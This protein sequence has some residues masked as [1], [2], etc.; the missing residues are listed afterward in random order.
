MRVLDRAI[1]VDNTPMTLR[2][3]RSESDT[4]AARWR[5]LVPCRAGLPLAAILSAASGYLIARRSLAPVGAMAARA[6]QITAERL[7]ARLPV[8]N[9]QD[10]LGQ[11][12]A[13]FNETLGRLENSF[14]ELRRFAADASHELRTPLTA[15]RAVGE[16]S[17]RERNGGNATGA[18]R[19][20]VASMLEEA[21]HLGELVDALLLLARADSGTSAQPRLETVALRPL[22]AEARESLLVLAEEKTQRIALEIGPSVVNL[23]AQADR[24][25]LR[26]ALLNLIHNAI[27][28]S[29][30]ET[31]IRLRLRRGEKGNDRSGGDRGGRRRPRYRPGA[32]GE[33]V[34]AVLPYRQGPVA[35]EGS[36]AGLGLAIARWAVE[37][38]GGRIELDSA[39][40]AGSVF[41]VVLP[42]QN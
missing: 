3:I 16:A 30:Q 7:S 20:A 14:A 10:E 35:E 38:Q 11:L 33:S 18:W 12:A 39:P 13:V 29:P 4:A 36:G 15:L 22:L 32:Q 34:R 19:E 40:G 27:R 25:L 37:R 8:S 24:A 17:L 26:Q 9:P 42:T 5:K 23:T 6:R 21:Q 28:Y 2:V 41:R 31:V 1:Q